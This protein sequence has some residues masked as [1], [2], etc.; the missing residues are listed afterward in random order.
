MCTR[1]FTPKTSKEA[2]RCKAEYSAFDEIERLNKRIVLLENNNDYYRSKY[3]RASRELQEFKNANKLIAKRIC[4]NT[5][6]V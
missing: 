5:S 4:F 1:G 2:L 6:I 3:I